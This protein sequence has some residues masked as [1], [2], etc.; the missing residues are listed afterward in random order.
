MRSQLGHRTCITG[1]QLPTVVAATVYDRWSAV[2]YARR[3]NTGITVFGHGKPCRVSYCYLVVCS[4][5]KV[6]VFIPHSRPGNASCCRVALGAF[7]THLH[8]HY[9]FSGASSRVATGSAVFVGCC[10][11]LCWRRNPL[12]A[13]QPR[14]S[15]P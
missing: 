14:T 9:K 5:G 10:T 7:V 11:D 4:L 8:A 6:V 2:S 13:P 1:G 3:E 15:A 12:V